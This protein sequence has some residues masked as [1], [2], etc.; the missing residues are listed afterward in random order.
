MDGKEVQM[1]NLNPTA[2]IGLV[3]F[4]VIAIGMLFAL[5]SCPPL[6]LFNQIVSS[7]GED[8]E[9]TAYYSEFQTPQTDVYLGTFD[10]VEYTYWQVT[11]NQVEIRIVLETGL[12]SGTGKQVHVHDPVHEGD[13]GEVITYN[14]SFEGTYDADLKSISGLVHVT[15]GKVCTANCAG[16]ENYDLDYFATW[17]GSL[18]EDGK[19]LWGY[20]DQW[21]GGFTV[22]K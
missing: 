4:L 1:T 19:T 12:V 6:D 22:N 15:G 14:L 18:S 3:F 16:V 21:Q 13:P 2:R 10:P 11:E 5:S 9:E 20:V 17:T 8:Y 7:G